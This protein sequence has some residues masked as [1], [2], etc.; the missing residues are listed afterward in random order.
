[1]AETPGLIAEDFRHRP[2]PLDLSKLDTET[3]SAM[4]L[5]NDDAMAELRRRVAADLGLPRPN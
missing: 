3:V 1:M 2:K 5:G 4:A